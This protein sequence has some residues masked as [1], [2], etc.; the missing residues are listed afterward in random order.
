MLI[1]FDGPFTLTLA[2]VV[3]PTTQLVTSLIESLCGYYAACPVNM[4]A[5]LHKPSIH[6]CSS[7]A[8]TVTMTVTTQLDESKA[9]MGR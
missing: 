2:Y 7:R 4:K 6:K 5:E 1:S 9:T 8:T 3:T